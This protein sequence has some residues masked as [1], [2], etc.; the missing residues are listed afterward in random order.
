[1][2]D[3][4]VFALIDPRDDCIFYVGTLEQGVK[5]N[6]HVADAVSDALSG[7]TSPADDQVRAILAADFDKPHAVILQ[8]E[9]SE[10][11]EAR[12]IETLEAAGNSLTN[13]R[14]SG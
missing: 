1:M 7:G 11:D 9:A 13:A 12:W 5:L 8:P 4:Y 10:A 14:P 6:E 3:R 2:G